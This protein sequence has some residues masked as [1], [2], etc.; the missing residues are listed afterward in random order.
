[1]H[2]GVDGSRET[3]RST[4]RFASVHMRENAFHRNCLAFG[5]IHVIDRA[6]ARNATLR[7]YPE[8]RLGHAIW[9]FASQALDLDPVIRLTGCWRTSHVAKHPLAVGVVALDIKR[10]PLI[11]RLALGDNAIRLE[12]GREIVALARLQLH[13]LPRPADLDLALRSA[14]PYE[15]TGTVV[16]GLL[17]MPVRMVAPAD[18]ATLA[19]RLVE[20]GVLQFNRYPGQ[21]RACQ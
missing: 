4:S 21:R 3:Y 1:M 18:S 14:F 5:K 7:N 19:I 17:G 2:I 15:R 8:I 12:D 6:S 20:P 16:P 11:D 13:F 10:K 9:N